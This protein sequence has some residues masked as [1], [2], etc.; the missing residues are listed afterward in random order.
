MLKWQCVLILALEYIFTLKWWKKRY[1]RFTYFRIL[2]FLM[3]ENGWKNP[4]F[5]F[6][7]FFGW[8]K[9]NKM[10]IFLKNTYSPGSVPMN[11][12]LKYILS[13]YLRYILNVICWYWYW[14]K[15]IF[16]IYFMYFLKYIFLQSKKFW[17]FLH[18][19][20]NMTY[21]DIS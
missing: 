20:I 16:T 2:F 10:V 12:F 5:F 9:E 15:Y 18:D 21:E 13:S 3:Y 4:F 11:G 14:D 6:F 17:F 1:G 7:F 19:N 8:K